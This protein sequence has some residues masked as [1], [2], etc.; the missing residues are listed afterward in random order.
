MHMFIC[1]LSGT[2]I[3]TGFDGFWPMMIS[4]HLNSIVKV[5]Y[6]SAMVGVD[7]QGY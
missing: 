7:Y 5:E 2:A 4:M 3:E 6:A 1:S